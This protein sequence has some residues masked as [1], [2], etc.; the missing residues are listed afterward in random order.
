[1]FLRTIICFVAC[2]APFTS[3]KAEAVCTAFADAYTG[4]MLKQDGVC[5]QR[6]TPASTFKIAISLMGYDSGFLKDTD[7]PA[8]PFREGYPDWIPSW[9]TTT[10]PASWMKNSVVWYSQ[11]ITQSLGIERFTRYVRAFGY[12]NEDVTGSPGKQDGLTR[13]WLSSSLKIS[14]QE[15]LMFLGKIVRRELPV[16]VHAYEMTTKISTLGTQPNGWRLY[17]KTGTGAPTNADGSQDWDHSF[18]WFIGWAVKDKRAIVFVHQVQDQKSEETNAGI[19]AR[20]AFLR[21]LPTVLDA[22]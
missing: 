19:R 1:M 6:I 22:I 7:L 5:D 13:A 11:Q 17:G 18:G 21:N 9:K 2:V 3:T 8:L 4:K 12:G 10:V 14:P 20:D 16:S 15:Q